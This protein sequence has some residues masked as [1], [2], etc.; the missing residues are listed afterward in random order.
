MLLR[1][2]VGYG[3]MWWVVERGL[4][5]GLSLW[6]LVCCYGHSVMHSYTTSS[7]Q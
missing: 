7:E 1:V 2:V 3:P 4:I 5:Y 6:L